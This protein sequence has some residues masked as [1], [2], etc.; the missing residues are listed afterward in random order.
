MSFF[1]DVADKV[2][3]RHFNDLFCKEKVGKYRRC[4]SFEVIGKGLVFR[5]EQR[6]FIELKDDMEKYIGFSK[7]ECF[8]QMQMMW[9]RSLQSKKLIVL[10]RS[11][12]NLVG[13]S[14]I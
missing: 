11:D 6:K 3:C 12:R 7:R 1:A 2:F 13:T 14:K 8:D 9:G 4:R 10:P 5:I